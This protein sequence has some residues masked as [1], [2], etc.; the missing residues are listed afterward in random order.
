MSVEYIHVPAGSGAN[1]YSWQHLK[2]LVGIRR[3]ANMDPRPKARTQ[4]KHNTLIFSVHITNIT[5][6]TTNGTVWMGGAGCGRFITETLACN[7]TYVT[8][9]FKLNM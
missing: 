7:N 6:Y 4:P 2:P 5:T 3:R 9:T 1:I 8:F